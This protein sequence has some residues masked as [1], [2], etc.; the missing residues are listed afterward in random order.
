MLESAAVRSRDGRSRRV[1]V[2]LISLGCAKNL[3][4]AEVMLG[5]LVERGA[6]ITAS[7]DEAEVVVVNTCGFIEDAQRESVEAILEV[8]SRK[9]KGG[10]QRL[11]VAGCM[12]QGYARELAAEVPEIDCFI[13]LDELER[14]PEAVLGR[15]GRSHFPD[16]HGA[17]RL[18]DHREPRLLTGGTVF[19][20]LK[21]AEGCDNPCTF[22]QIPRMR[23]GFR[24][25][26]LASLVEEAVRI[27]AAGVTELVLVAQDTTRYGEDL[28]LG[29]TG[30]QRLLEAL[31]AATKFPWI[32]FLYAYPATLDHGLFTLMGAEPRLAPYLDLPLQ[33]VSRRVLKAMKRG[34]SVRE[35]RDLIAKARSAVPDLAVRSAFIVG[36][37]GE[38][39]EDVDELARFLEEVK[40]DHV[41][42]FTYSFQ[43]ANPGALLGDPIPRRVKESRRRRLMR[44]QQ[45]ISRERYRTLR[46]S[47]RVA[48]V[49]GA[50]PES[51]FLLEGRLPQQA[52]EVDGRVLFTAGTAR[53]GDLVRVRIHKTYAFEVLAEIVDVIH[54]APVAPPRL[55]PSLPLGRRAAL[56]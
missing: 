44:L 5:H 55:L 35:Y 53:P 38:E 13:G 46:G 40:L 33:H 20:Y 11:V 26:D 16:Q 30:L 42:V 25:R 27:E 50:S 45:G 15:L 23:G 47:E 28:G 3:V 12:A 1:R 8:A 32:R 34:G 36:F 2:G 4:D 21:V 51:E 31:L 17:I 29:R 19:A 48:L 56:G 37:P 43:A 54:R 10:L 6:E 7:L 22:C 18:Y 49:T 52:P 39:D 41:G 14:V 9:G 24:S